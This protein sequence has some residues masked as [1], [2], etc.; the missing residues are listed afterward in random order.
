MATED[1]L[2]DVRDEPP[3]RRDRLIFEYIRRARLRGG[4]RPRRTTDDPKPLYDEF[5]AEHA[6]AFSPGTTWRRGPRPGG[7]ASAAPPLRDRG[8]VR[9]AMGVP[10][11]STIVRVGT[12]GLRPPVGSC[13]W[14]LTASRFHT[15]MAAMAINRR[16]TSVSS[17]I[18]ST[19]AHTG[20]VCGGVADAR[21]RLGQRQGRP[22]PR[23][24]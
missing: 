12:R 19:S 7:C 22:L 24:V 4:V 15:L 18:G 3:A 9:C 5:A 21:H 16:T 11:G 17:S 14:V 8:A 23:C 13:W 2:L 1:R 20:S 10:N 6:G